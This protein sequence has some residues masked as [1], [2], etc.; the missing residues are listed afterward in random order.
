MAKKKTTKKKRAVARNP[1]KKKTA[2]KKTPTKKPA[3]RN[4]SVAEQHERELVARALDKRR[5]GLEPATYE[6]RALAKFERRREEET[7]WNYYRSIPQKHWREMSGKSTSQLHSQQERYGIPFGERSIDLPAW[8][9]VCMRS[10]RRTQG[11]STKTRTG[12]S[13]REET[14]RRWRSF[15]LTRRLGK[16]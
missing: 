10:W 16:S 13:C 11:D 15:E 3:A 6:L 8:F 9:A 1:A 5:R 14:L 2:K 7:R 12:L 4:P